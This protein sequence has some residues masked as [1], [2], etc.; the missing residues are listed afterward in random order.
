MNGKDE[1][2]MNG[3]WTGY[4]EAFHKGSQVGLT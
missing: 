3:H 2:N 4:C 1:Y